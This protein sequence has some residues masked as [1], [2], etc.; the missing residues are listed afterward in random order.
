MNIYEKLIE[1]RRTVPYLKK[2]NSGYQFNYVSSSQVLGNLK[3]KMDEVGL[4]LIPKVT[5][6]KV[7][8]DTYEKNNKRTTDYFTEVDMTFTWVNAEKPEETIECQWY[9]QGIDTAGEKGV[10]KAMTYSEKYFMLKFFNIP[11][12]KDDPDTFQEKHEDKP[13]AKPIE[14]PK[15]KAPQKPIDPVPNS[16]R[17][18]RIK[19]LIELAHKKGFGEKAILKKAGITM[20]NFIKNELIDTYMAEFEKL[21]DKAVE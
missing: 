2:E 18:K 3:N 13:P 17:E 1:V 6:T 10:G 19:D 14:P 5:G 16:Q 20:I 9:G 8:I 11:T 12:D 15:Q 4:L 21:P 7:T